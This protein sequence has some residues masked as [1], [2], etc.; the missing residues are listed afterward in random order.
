M[1]SSAISHTSVEAR[2]RKIPLRYFFK[3]PERTAYQISPDGQYVAFLKP[4]KRR[5]NIYVQRIGSTKAV[6]LTNELERDIAGFFWKGNDTLLYLRDFKG[7]ENF[8]LFAVKTMITI[9]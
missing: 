4:Y 2:R 5:Q 3:K 7:D 9:Y 6:R 8:H 1:E